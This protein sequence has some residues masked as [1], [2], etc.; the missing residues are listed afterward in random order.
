MARQAIKTREFTKEESEKMIADAIAAREYRKLRLAELLKIQQE[1]PK[2]LSGADLW[3]I[4]L[5]K[6]I[7]ADEDERNAGN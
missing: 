3:E 7:K 5:L 6:H 4:K 1:S 2:K